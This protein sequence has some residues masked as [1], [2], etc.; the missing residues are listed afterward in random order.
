M[1]KTSAKA[2]HV[3][4]GAMFAGCSG[5]AMLAASEVEV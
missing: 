2:G 4:G 1:G 3:E 5:A